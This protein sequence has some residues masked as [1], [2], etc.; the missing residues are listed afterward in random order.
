MYVVWAI[1]GAVLGGVIGQGIAGAAA[2]FAIGLLWARLSQTRRELDELRAQVAAAKAPAPAP[3]TQPQ[4]PP[5]RAMWLEVL[6]EGVAA[7][8]E[9]LQ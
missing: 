3:S 4:P 1:V 5:Q 6:P 9:R 8:C 2:G 7:L